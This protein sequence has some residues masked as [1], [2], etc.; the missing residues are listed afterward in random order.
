MPLVASAGLL[1]SWYSVA[2]FGSSAIR[3]RLG[4]QHWHWHGGY[5]R[6]FTIVS[7]SSVQSVSAIRLVVG[8]SGWSRDAGIA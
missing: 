5:E 4:W 8:P 1:G 3:W 6:P 7:E 2:L